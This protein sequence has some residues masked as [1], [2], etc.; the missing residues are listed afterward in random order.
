MSTRVLCV[1]VLLA[2]SLSGPAYSQTP[3][4]AQAG[5]VPQASVTPQAAATTPAPVV[6][7]APA[8]VAEQITK[9]TPGAAGASADASDPGSEL[10]PDGSD[11]SRTVKAIWIAR[12]VEFTYYSTTSLYYCDGLREKVK[13]VMKQLGATDAS[14]INV[15]SCFNSGANGVTFGPILDPL[16]RAEPSPR[17]VIEVVVPQRVTP[18]LLAELSEGQGERELIDR[19]RGE[20]SVVGNPEAQFAASTRQVTFD[21][22]ARRG[23]IDPGDCEL[24]EQMRDAVFVP[25]GFKI[26]E[27]NLYC[28]P[29]RVTPGSVNLQV[30]VLEPWK[31][32]P[33]PGQTADPAAA[34]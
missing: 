12:E 32:P 23:R 25:L 15:R 19:V 30:E 18:E 13:W 17:V 7:Q 34:Q 16:S 31:P 1:A 33:E 5:E 29:N 14:K 9:I 28:A 3:A 11:P 8:D 10:K 22:G 27:D 24:I 2:G 20:T 6:P 4:D 21:D 26:V